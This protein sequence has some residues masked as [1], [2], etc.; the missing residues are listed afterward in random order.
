MQKM[1]SIAYRV[2]VIY[3]TPSSTA[4]NHSGTHGYNLEWLPDDVM[5]LLW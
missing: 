2:E 5:I 1:D 3:V 4:R